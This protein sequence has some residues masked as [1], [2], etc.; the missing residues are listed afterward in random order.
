MTFKDLM[1]ELLKIKNQAKTI[2]MNDKAIGNLEI[3]EVGILN[4]IEKKKLVISLGQKGITYYLLIKEE[5]Q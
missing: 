4:S 3:V 1:T 2:G 5:K